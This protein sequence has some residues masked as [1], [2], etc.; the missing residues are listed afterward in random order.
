MKK[1]ILYVFIFLFA[2]RAQAAEKT[3]ALGAEFSLTGLPAISSDRSQSSFTFFPGVGLSASYHVHNDVAIVLRGMY[4]VPTG[5]TRIEGAVIK[6][7]IGN[8]YFQQ[9]V[10]LTTVG[11]RLESKTWFWPMKM[12][13]A[14]GLG[15]TVFIATD[16]E[17]RNKNEV[18]YKVDLPTE[19]KVYPTLSL[20]LGLSGPV[21][22]YVRL[23]L[24]PSLYLLM[25]RTSFVGFGAHFLVSFPLFI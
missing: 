17:L 18:I 22:K 21:H 2:F 9:H 6:D 10:I 7:R 12:W 15:P 19:T 1:F 11:V 25:G 24:E 8:Y 3:L 16:R 13:I 20:S 5:D 14:S 4:G 23:G